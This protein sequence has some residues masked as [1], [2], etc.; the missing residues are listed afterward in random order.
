LTSNVIELTGVARHFGAL[1]AVDGVD[2]SIAAG[3]MFGLIGHNG[4]GKTT[5]FKLMLGLL[6][7]SAGR[8]E[9]GGVAVRGEQFRDVRRRIGFMP[10]SASLYGNLTG[11]ETL[12]FFAKLK[13]A[14]PSSCIALLERVG[15]AGAAQR[16]VR[17]YSKGMLQRLLFAQALLGNPRILFLDEPTHGLDPVG[18][19]DFYDILR[20]LRE[21]GVTVVLTSHILAEVEQRVDRLALMSSGRV[22]ATGTVDALRNALDLPLGFDVRLQAGAERELRAALAPLAGETVHV[23]GAL[24]TFQCARSVKVAVLNAL[25][26]LGD[27]LLDVNIKE[28]TLEDVFMGY[29][30][31]H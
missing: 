10:E 6:E 14:E 1:R 26:G 23:S 4:A 17:H 28:P 9:I 2:L 24:A 20:E 18:V 25:S 29:R 11:L 7:P 8:L 5:L 27:R 15:L 3:E 13:R 21:D 16:Q 12:R 22:Q 31:A 19:R 30:G